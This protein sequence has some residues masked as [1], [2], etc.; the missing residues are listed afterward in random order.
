MVEAASDKQAVSLLR[1]QG[2]F[3]ISLNPVS[4][5]LFSSLS[6]RFSKVSFNDIVHFTQQLSTMITAGLP[7]TDSLNILK[8]QATNPAFSKVISEMLKE[9]EG[10]SSFSQALEKY[11]QYF[12]HIYVS[13]IKAG[14]ASGKLQT[15]LERLSSNLDKQR[16]FRSK[17]QGALVYPAIIVV[18]MVIVVFIMM[19]FVVPKLTSLYKDFGTEL[20]P[21]TKL[22]IFVSNFFV[23][24]WWLLIIM[25][26][27]GLLLFRM[28]K[29]TPLGGRLWD[30]FLFNLPIWGNL[31]KQVVLTDFTRT[32]AILVS[33]GIPIL[34]SLEIVGGAVNSVVYQ[35]DLREVAKQVEKGFPLGLPI[36]QNPRFP[37]ILG[38]MVTVG[39]ETGKLDE[40]LNKLSSFFEAES[41]QGIK[42]LTTAMEPLIMVVLGVGVGFVVISILMPIYNLTSK[43]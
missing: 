38:Q 1:S 11:P 22:L 32:L 12:T 14:E 20:P 19:T 17:T 27:G 5:S 7:L 40:T 36:S 39:E 30:Q 33:A 9:V 43:F 13:L 23:H 3:I 26:W 25:I 18:G 8:I 29:K 31:K 16:E 28:W 15:V 21:T 37:P 42:T 34:D 35:D 24:F 10:G 4:P 2:L 41:E 6:F